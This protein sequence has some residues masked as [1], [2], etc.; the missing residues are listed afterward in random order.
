MTRINQLFSIA[1]KINKDKNVMLYFYIFE[2]LLISNAK[3]YF[4][5]CEK[6]NL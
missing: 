2:K 6:K 3:K 5:L 4:D 1:K